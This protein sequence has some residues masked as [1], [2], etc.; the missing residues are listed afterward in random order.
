[1]RERGAAALRRHLDN[2]V[3]TRRRVL[4]EAAN[5]GR[6]EHFL[7]VRLAKPVEP[8]TILDIAVGGHDG[9]HLLAA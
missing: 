4:A 1:L 9:T 3:G 5:L 8:G 7:P 6:S 2:E